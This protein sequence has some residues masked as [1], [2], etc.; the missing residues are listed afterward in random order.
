VLSVLCENVLPR[1]LR[2]NLVRLLL[3]ML[4]WVRPLLSLLQE[5]LQRRRRRLD[6]Q[7]AR[8]QKQKPS[9]APEQTEK[10]IAST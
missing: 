1:L 9:I 3:P 7:P 8:R 2:K 10:Q 4:R 5:V 6:A